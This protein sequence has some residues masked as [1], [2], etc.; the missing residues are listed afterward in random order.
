MTSLFEDPSFMLLIV[1]IHSA[2]VAL[3]QCEISGS[4]CPKVIHH[5]LPKDQD[6]VVQDESRIEK[7]MRELLP[8]LRCPK[9]S[10]QRIRYE[11]SFSSVEVM[12]RRQLLSLPRD[13][14]IRQKPTFSRTLCNRGGDEMRVR[15]ESKPSGMLGL[16]QIRIV[17]EYQIDLISVCFWHQNYNATHP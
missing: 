13:A 6:L 3:Y 8:S 2:K 16:L 1:G 4:F 10:W 5:P 11:V 17:I 14:E 7:K 15:I 12:R 9:R